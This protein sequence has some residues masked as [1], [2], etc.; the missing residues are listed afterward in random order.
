MLCEGTL[1]IEAGKTADGVQKLKIEKYK[2]VTNGHRL[3]VRPKQPNNLAPFYCVC[4]LFFLFQVTQTIFIK[5]WSIFPA[6]DNFYLKTTCLSSR[7]A[8]L[9]SSGCGFVPCYCEHWKWTSRTKHRQQRRHL[10]VLEQDFENS[11][12]MLT[13]WR[14][15]CCW[16]FV[17]TRR[18]KACDPQPSNY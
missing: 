2:I 10:V 9:S 1:L 13:N 6:V 8:G 4:V 7:F 11:T 17:S 5:T 18:R 16:T 3:K 15:Y 12:S 14:C